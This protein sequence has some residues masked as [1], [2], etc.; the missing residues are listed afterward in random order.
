MNMLGMRSQAVFHSAVEGENDDLWAIVSVRRKNRRVGRRELDVRRVG[1]GKSR[2]LLLVQRRRLEGN[3]YEERGGEHR[4][5]ALNW[6]LRFFE[7]W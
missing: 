7:L 2:L 5:R 1:R 4:G 6:P 3:K